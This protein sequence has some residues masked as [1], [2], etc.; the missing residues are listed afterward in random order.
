VIGPGAVC[1]GDQFPRLGG[2]P[3]LRRAS[4]QIAR[5]CKHPSHPTRR[6]DRKGQG[7]RKNHQS[8]MRVLVYYKVQFV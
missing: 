4:S 2:K 3:F 6:G 1:S 7:R 8:Y 5:V